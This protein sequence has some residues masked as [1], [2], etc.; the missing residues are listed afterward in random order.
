M[1]TGGG[2]GG[3][4]AVALAYAAAGADVVVAARTS[5]EI[6]SCAEQMR[7]LGRRAL[8]V[9]TDVADPSQVDSLFEATRGELGEVDILVNNAAGPS[10]VG[11]LWQI[12]SDDWRECMQ[13]NLDS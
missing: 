5:A 8:A 6:D 3:G 2:R 7:A 13:V 10:G 11:D 1:V 9:P 4:R 12:E